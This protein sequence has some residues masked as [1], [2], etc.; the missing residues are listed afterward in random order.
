MIG[1][2]SFT[3][4]SAIAMLAIFSVPFVNQVT[5]AEESTLKVNSTEKEL[6]LPERVRRVPEDNDYNDVESEYSFKRMVQADNIAIF[7]S[8]EYGD[9]PMTDPEERRRFDVNYMLKECERFYDYYVNELKFVE[10]GKS[11]TDK[12]K[13]L[14]YVFGGDS[15]TAS[16]GGC[17]I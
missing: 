1:F 4:L 2:R 3:K 17:G 13:L 5:A 7:W 14:V 11:L 10:K 6:Y 15:G 12:Y 16:G 8:K 9:D